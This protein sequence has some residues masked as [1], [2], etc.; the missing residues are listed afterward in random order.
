MGR[1]LKPISNHGTRCCWNPSDPTPPSPSISPLHRRLSPDGF[2]CVAGPG[3]LTF[4]RAVWR[5][6]GRHSRWRE[7]RLVKWLGLLV[8]VL[9]VGGLARAG[10]S[11]WKRGP[12]GFVNADTAQK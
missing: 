11:A 5:H 12:G 9:V 10:W 2:L 1:H 4:P 7:E 6:Q 3:P 8:V